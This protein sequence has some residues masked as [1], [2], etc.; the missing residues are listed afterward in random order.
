MKTTALLLA[1]NGILLASLSAQTVP[2][3]MNYQ[4][5]VTDSTGAGLGTPT[6]ENR[7]IVFRIYDAATAGNLLWTEEQTVTIGNGVFSV[8]LGQGIPFAA[9]SKPA[10]D[11]VFSGAGSTRFLGITVDNGD[12]TI[13]GSDT[14]V[15][16][17]QQI[18]STAYSFHA[19]TAGSIATGSNL[20]LN[21]SADYGLGYYGAGRPFGGIDVDGPVLFGLG[22]GALGSANGATQE[23]ALN[24]NDDGNVGI[25]VTSPTEKLDLAG[26]LK[27]SGNLL[28]PNYLSRLQGSNGYV[29]FEDLG[30]GQGGMTV[31]NTGSMNLVIDSDNNNT[32]RSFHILS[33]GAN[34]GSAGVS[35][36]MSIQEGG[37][38][39]IGTSSPISSLHVFRG[40]SGVGPN[41]SE[42]S[43][44]L[45]DDATHWLEL[46]KP[47]NATTGILFGIPTSGADGNIRYN[48][49]REME[50]RT[51]G[52]FLRM[53]IN[54]SGNVGIGTSAPDNRL[55][56]FN[57]ASGAP[58]TTTATLVL[59]DDASHWLQFKAP[60][61]TE[62]GIAFGRPGNAFD[63]SIRYD[64]NRD[65][66]FRTGG[67][68]QRMVITSGGNVGI[69]TGTPGVPLDV[70][71][72]PIISH[73]DN[74]SR[75]FTKA[76]A[77][78][79]NGHDAYTSIRS[80]WFVQAF[81]FVAVSDQRIKDVVCRSDSASDLELIQKLQVTDYRMVDT[82]QS[83]ES[84]HKG[85]IA[86]E[87]EEII[88]EAVNKGTNFVPT[89]YQQATSVECDP[90][91][92]LATLSL[93]NDHDLE[94]GDLVRM[95][96]DNGVIERTVKD[97]PSRS[98]FTIETQ[99][100]HWDRLFVYGKQ[101][102]DFRSVDYDR[103]FTTAVSALQQLKKEKDQEVGELKTVVETMESRLAAQAKELADLRAKDAARDAKLVAIET[104]L[105]SMA[106]PPV[107]TAALKAAE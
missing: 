12:G 77:L 74:A 71:G 28:M 83:G 39:G 91:E 69:G 90:A 30:A 72:Q 67:G 45:E 31:S 85:F 6:P 9:E 62:T 33:N 87:V 48:Q 20:V 82:I 2:L 5:R 104:L 56:L 42:S 10:I 4:G 66:T 102:D 68:N 17:R 14:E 44:V 25:G 32:D 106:R 103:I 84:V 1:L 98:S 65:I 11:T 34:R 96:G 78:A 61:S 8:L 22:G 92:S 73:G 76:N 46:R 23:I 16:P 13:N 57:G 81:G 21:N 58:S 43:L 24:W 40:T 64:G 19:A 79:T 51:G 15:S 54:S 52:N 55:H 26:N 86:Q 101:V 63:G 95:M 107:Q 75:W 100:E 97:V 27:V 89:I 18:T 47:A 36:L 41:A 94:V 53:L 60:N 3:F 37:N 105:K 29:G 80:Q 99:G 35:T 49:N 38:V 93:E 50:F 70:I 59:E 7:K 88:P